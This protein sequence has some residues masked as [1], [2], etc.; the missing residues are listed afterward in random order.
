MY[1]AGPTY[2][3]GTI[4]VKYLLGPSKK[5]CEKALMAAPK[6]TDPQFKLRMPQSLKDALDRTVGDSGRTLNAEIVWRL[7]RSFDLAKLIDNYRLAEER[8]LEQAKT[9]RELRNQIE[10]LQRQ[11]DRFEG[12]EDWLRESA[13]RIA[14]Q[15][16]TLREMVASVLERE[17]QLQATLPTVPDVPPQGQYEASD[18]ER[19]FVAAQHALV[20]RLMR[21][22]G[23]NPVDPTELEPTGSGKPVVAE[24]SQRSQTAPKRSS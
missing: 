12:G 24:T 17:T 3:I 14:E 10:S 22:H 7:E 2:L 9:E 19:E 5:I 16:E 4:L 13:Q 1:L 11:L 21:K 8:L 6:Q 18:F 20:M 23:M 15:S